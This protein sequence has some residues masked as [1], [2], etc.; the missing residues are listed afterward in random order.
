M[1]KHYLVYIGIMNLITQMYRAVMSSYTYMAS[2]NE[3]LV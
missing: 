1:L 2:E 3:V